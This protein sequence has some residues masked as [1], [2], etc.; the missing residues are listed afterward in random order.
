M[1][2]ERDCRNEYRQEYEPNDTA[3]EQR[4]TVVPPRI[5]F[6]L[7]YNIRI[8]GEFVNALSRT[9]SVVRFGVVNLTMFKNGWFGATFVVRDWC[10]SRAEKSSGKT[11]KG[12]TIAGEPQPRFASGKL[13]MGSVVVRSRFEFGR[14]VEQFVVVHGES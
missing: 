8:L 13:G 12:V 10:S 14:D 6:T 9:E 1:P 2:P 5:S 7:R 3:T 11:K 4:A